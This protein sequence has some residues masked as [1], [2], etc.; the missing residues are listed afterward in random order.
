MRFSNVQWHGM[1]DL[2][3]RHRRSNDS[4][5]SRFLLE[6]FLNII[7][8]DYTMGYSDAEIAIQDVNPENAEIFKEGWMYV[9]TLKNKEAPLYF[10]P[11]FTQLGPN[12]GISMVS[13]VTYSKVV[14]LSDNV[15]VS[16]APSDEHRKRWLDGLSL[17]RKR[18][19]KEGFLQN[20]VRLFFLDCPRTWTTTPIL[21]KSFNE[22]NPPKRIPPR[23]PRG[24][25]LECDDL[26]RA[27]SG[28]GGS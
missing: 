1:I 2:V 18:A 24:F 6:Q 11:Y 13:R 21:K 16:D 17:L 5:E 14:K 10:A 15:D 20:E 7:T 4:E 9:T 22:T 26:V 12:S 25:S 19:K 8:G 27:C 3:L 28:T 23:I